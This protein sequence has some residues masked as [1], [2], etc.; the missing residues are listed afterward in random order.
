MENY[1]E[2]KLY[3]SS[4]FCLQLTI[5]PSHELPIFYR[6]TERKQN[7]LIIANYDYEFK[8]DYSK[9]IELLSELDKVKIS[10]NPKLAIGVDGSMNHL[11]INNQGFNR[12]EFVWWEN[13]VDENW[14]PLLRIKN[15]LIELFND[16]RREANNG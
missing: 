9:K 2:S 3:E 4:I 16:K 5:K 6:I 13:V 12:L 8:I 7:E 1:D 15:K 11:T 14:K 10:I